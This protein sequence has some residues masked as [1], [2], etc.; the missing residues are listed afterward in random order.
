MTV[1]AATRRLVRQ[2]AGHTRE[3]CRTR[4]LDEPFTTYQIEHVIALQHGGTDADDNL[5][6]AC[7][8]CNLQKGPNLAGTQTAYIPATT[9][10]ETSALTL[11]PTMHAAPHGPEVGK[12]RRVHVRLLSGH[13]EHPLEERIEAGAAELGPLLELQPAGVALARHGGFL[14]PTLQRDS[15]D[16]ATSGGGDVRAGHYSLPSECALQKKSRTVNPSR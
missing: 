8:H 7:S 16:R 12:D 5:A 11:L 4:Q 1:A 6:L 13:D 15:G 3:Y 14:P 9:A 2:R 10:G